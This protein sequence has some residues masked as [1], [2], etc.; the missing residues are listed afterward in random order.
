MSRRASFGS[1]GPEAEFTVEV[2]SLQLEQYLS[3]IK[4]SLSKH[5][6]DCK[7]VQILSRKLDLCMLDVDVIRDHFYRQKSQIAEQKMIFHGTTIEYL[8]AELE[9]LRIVTRR[10]DLHQATD[11]TIF[12]QIKELQREVR[13]MKKD[14]ESSGSVGEKSGREK[15]KNKRDKKIA[16]IHNSVIN[17]LKTMEMELGTAT[18]GPNGHQT[19]SPFFDYHAKH[20]QMSFKSSL[21]ALSAA[22]TSTSEAAANIATEIT[23]TSSGGLSRSI[24]KLNSNEEDSSKRSGRK[25]VTHADQSRPEYNNS[26]ENDKENY[27]PNKSYSSK[28]KSR[29]ILM[30]ARNRRRNTI[31]GDSDS[32]GSDDGNGP[33][34]N[35]EFEELVRGM[36]KHQTA[37]ASIEQH[38]LVLQKKQIT[39]ATKDELAEIAKV[40]KRRLKKI[41]KGAEILSSNLKRITLKSVR[42]LFLRW[43]SQVAIKISIVPKRSPISEH[44]KIKTPP[45]PSKCL[46]VLD[47]KPLK[48]LDSEQEFYER[49]RKGRNSL[50]VEAIDWKEREKKSAKNSI[51]DKMTETITSYQDR[52]FNI[53]TSVTRVN[54]LA[55]ILRP[56]YQRWKA[57]Y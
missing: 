50:V 40:E 49:K 12:D 24:R 52:L 23:A 56:R 31:V 37:I 7:L 16:P 9:A 3:S 42:L 53:A 33:G 38:L 36:D 19:E 27:S 1:N 34:Y 20:S 26:D 10:I 25:E 22:A 4:E 15:T 2:K 44:S 41:T 21:D 47:S 46:K 55:V 35:S 57:R 17:P 39:D 51:D 32:E 5:E 18:S 54:W 6:E 45:I 14:K 11:G 48:V 43:N 8:R 30:L 13:M 29:K 28:W